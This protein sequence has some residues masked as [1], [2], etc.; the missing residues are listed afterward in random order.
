MTKK[1]KCLGFIYNAKITRHLKNALSNNIHNINNIASCFE[2]IYILN[3]NNFNWFKKNEHGFE[4]IFR[5][6]SFNKKIKFYNPKNSVEL[7]SFFKDKDFHGIISLGKTV[8]ELPIHLLLKKHNVKFFQISNIG[9]KN[10][11]DLPSKKSF[12]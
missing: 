3:L 1:K 10:I 9:N 12:L 8:N 11:G 4:K 5:D 7:D 6:F 2:E